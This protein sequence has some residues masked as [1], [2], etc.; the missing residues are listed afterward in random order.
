MISSDYPACLTISQYKLRDRKFRNEGMPTWNLNILL[1]FVARRLLAWSFL[2]WFID[3]SIGV[4]WTIRL[5][6]VQ[7]QYGPSWNI[8]G[9]L[10]FWADMLHTNIA[11]Q[12]VELNASWSDILSL[13]CNS[14][15]WTWTL[16]L[17]S[18]LTAGG[19]FTFCRSFIPHPISTT[20]NSSSYSLY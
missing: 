14:S 19:I 10:F 7:P 5:R 13:E 16:I 1:F 11:F 4:S 18:S 6:M 15:H 20:T 17:S 12:W 2:S 3:T 8:F 9:L